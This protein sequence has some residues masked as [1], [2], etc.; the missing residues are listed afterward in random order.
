MQVGYRLCGNCQCQED[1]LQC[2]LLTQ[3]L[4]LF[5]FRH[6]VLFTGDLGS[7]VVVYILCVY[8]D[9]F[10]LSEMCLSVI[11][12]QLT[13]ALATELLTYAVS[14]QSQPLKDLCVSVI[15]RK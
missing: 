9:L 8:F 15:G 2:S 12:N 1:A 3:C 14:V 7:V 13:V 5:S 11:R 6:V 10:S 4:V